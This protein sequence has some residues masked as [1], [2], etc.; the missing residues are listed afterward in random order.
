[1]HQR[2]CFQVRDYLKCMKNSPC[3]LLEHQ[4]ICLFLFL[5]G[6]DSA[7]VEPTSSRPHPL[8]ILGV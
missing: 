8:V 4:L 3:L 6:P 5:H 1:M 7:G 2:R